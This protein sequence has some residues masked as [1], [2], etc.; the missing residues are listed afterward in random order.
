M[1]KKNNNALVLFTK[2]PRLGSVKTRLQ[3]ELTPEQSLVLF[4]AMVEDMV[5]QF[6]DVGFCDV[7]IFFYPA[8]AH[9]E[10]KNWLGD[11]LDYFPQHG[12]DLGEKMHNAIAEMLNLKY[13]KVVLVGSDIPTLD[14]ITIV[15]AFTNLDNYDVALGPSKDGGYYLIGMK[16]PYPA[17]FQDMAWSTSLVLQ[18]T[19][20]KVRKAQLDIV[21]LEVKSDIDSYVEVVELW[22]YL[23]KQNMNGVNSYKSK[24]YE[25]LKKL[26]EMEYAFSH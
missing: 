4:R 12:K 24:T 8:N 5:S 26:F 21:Q 17:L 16:K 23:K 20:Q 6:D 13:D 3:P 7:K 11:Q 10:M 15:R 19:I 25:V 9:G 18:Q 1:S 22:N 2:A 14:S